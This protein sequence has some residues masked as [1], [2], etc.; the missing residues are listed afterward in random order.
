M[1]RRLF[2]FNLNFIIFI[3]IKKKEANENRTRFLICGSH[4]FKNKFAINREKIFSSQSYIRKLEK[5][6]F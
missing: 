5:S 4:G 3:L 1:Y 6:L 2:T